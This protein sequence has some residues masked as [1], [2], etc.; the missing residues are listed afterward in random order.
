MVCLSTVNWDASWAG[1]RPE[2]V[3]LCRQEFVVFRPEKFHLSRK[4]KTCCWQ[5]CW[6]LQE[7]VTVGKRRHYC[8]K[9]E[10]GEYP[11]N[12]LGRRAQFCRFVLRMLHNVAYFR[13]W[14]F[15]ISR[16]AHC[17][18]VLNMPCWAQAIAVA[19]SFKYSA[20]HLKDR[21]TSPVNCLSGQIAWQP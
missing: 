14:I 5:T 10:V 13:S 18:L 11:N 12:C 1:R 7:A 9:M 19:L 21:G 20:S 2:Y 17:R 3:R 16:R 6:Q 15:Y 4:W 8:M